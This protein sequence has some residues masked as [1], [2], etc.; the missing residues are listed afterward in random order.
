MT[1]ASKRRRI[2]PTSSGMA[3]DSSKRASDGK[4]S[5]SVRA[6]DDADAYVALQHAA[7]NAV[8]D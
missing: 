2:A 3:H 4:Q 7:G 5:A 6:S 1:M 8:V